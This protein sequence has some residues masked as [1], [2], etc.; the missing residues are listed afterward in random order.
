MRLSLLLLA[1][2]TALAASLT[3]LKAPT[4]LLWKIAI[5]V[6]E[7]GHWVIPFPILLIV[8][9]WCWAKNPLWLRGLVC[10]LGFVALLLLLKPHVQAR[11]LSAEV[12]AKL[13]RTFGAVEVGATPYSPAALFSRTP[14]VKIETHAYDTS[15]P[16]APLQLDFYRPP[17]SS[18]D[19]SARRPCV[20]V[21]HSGGWT[22]GTRNEFTE[23][24][25]QLAARGF[26]VA[27]IDYRLAP[28]HRW[29]A[30]REDGRKALAYLKTHAAVLGLDPTRFVL[31]GRSAGGQ[32]AQAIA[33]D[34]PDPAI[35]GVIS[36][37]APADLIFAWKHTPERDL[38]DSRQ[39]MR[40]YL[41]GSPEERPAA[42]ES[43][44]PIRFVTAKA[45]PSLLLHG[46]RDALV[47]FRQTERLAENL[48]AAGAPH[49]FIAVPWATHAF[50]YNP[51]GPGG[52]LAAY[53]IE[54]FLRAV[55][56]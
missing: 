5:L 38:L 36:L 23:L 27:S 39:L 8:L 2:T 48:S 11:N 37:Y 40:D 21:I 34:Q 4:L 13:L 15:D 46:E 45:P 50:D 24:N 22:A 51:H 7:F 47:W 3:T 35:R 44:S 18:A 6:G 16:H 32:I 43:A 20:I 33:Y 49:V 17:P 54:Y 56:Q 25:H 28:A 19:P 52:Q 9:G 55:V 10:G 1:L 14:Q 31:L 53:A 29:P 41:G 42:F 26:A 12:Q 30:T